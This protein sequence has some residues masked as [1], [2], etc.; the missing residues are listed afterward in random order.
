MVNIL[1]NITVIVFV[2]GILEAIGLTINAIIPWNY[3]TTTF[4]VIRYFL[5]IF[6]FIWDT[7]TLIL[8][9]GISFSIQVSI[10][11]YKAGLIVVNFFKN[12]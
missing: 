6:S 9:I 4:S 10:W 8:L 12:N 1:K 5:N 11:T 3:L 2:V 7:D